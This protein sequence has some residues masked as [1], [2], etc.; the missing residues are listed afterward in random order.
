MQERSSVDGKDEIFSH[1][2]VILAVSFVV[3]G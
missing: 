2:A 3:V 1:D